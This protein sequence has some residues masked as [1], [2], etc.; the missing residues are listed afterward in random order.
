M[1][2]RRQFLGSMALPTGAI[3]AG[4]NPAAGLFR[5]PSFRS[6]AH[7]IA[8]ELSA[9][10][11][12]PAEIARQ[13][14]FWTEVA[15]AFTV[16]RS[17]VNLNNGGVS[18]SPAW[19]QDAMKRHLDYSNEAPPYTM[20]QILEPQREG[21]R[22]RMAR[23]WDVDAEEVAFTRNASESL[24]TMQLGLDLKP[25]DEVL[26]TTQDYGR[27]ITTFDQRVRREGIVLT[28]IQIPTPAED[29]AEVVRLFEEAITPQTRVILCCHMINL[30]GQILPVKEI[31]AMARTHGIP[32]IVD[33]AHALAHF[34]FTISELEVDN[35]STSLHKW[36]FAPHG[37]GLLYVRRDK[38]GEVWP[39]MAAPE[40]MDENIRKFEEIGTHPAANYLAI[41]E[42][43]TFHQGI[44]SAR[45]DA[46]LVYLRDYWARPLLEEDR[47]RLHTSLKPG[48][49][50]GIA[51]VE[52][53]GE[54]TSAVQQWLWKNHRIFTVAINHDE[55]TGLRVSPSVY[56]T[57]EELD[58]FVDAMTVVAHKGLPA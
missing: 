57:L 33:G 9:V 27:M 11:G 47:I 49:A 50:C 1:P 35:Y 37:T 45:K 6:R 52:V 46:R 39:L 22:Q 30:T 15:Q 42:A 16:D 4:A 3:L 23:E 24:Q 14:D 38:I 58:R 26:T 10:E 56:S 21:V 20:W 19:V 44:G 36:L 41:G 55:F 43:L 7:D 40:G 12:A 32:V 5:P 51:C 25:G 28:Q 53:Q 17:L 48:F 54:N 2:T 31:T 34:D 8:R 18:P 29:P 13:E